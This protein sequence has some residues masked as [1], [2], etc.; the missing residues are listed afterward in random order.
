MQAVLLR[1]LGTRFGVSR[2]R[3]INGDTNQSGRTKRILEDFSRSSGF[4]VLILSPLAAGVGLNI[5]A[6]NH[7]IHYDRWWNP[8]KEDQAT[9]RAYRIGQEREVNVHYLLLHHPDDGNAGFDKRLH[10]L[11]EGKRGLAHDFL[12]PTDAAELRSADLARLFHGAL[13]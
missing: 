4:D 6:A 11:V 5:V 3:V 9:D 8:A 10:E 13:P 1:S 7:V 12:C 2:D